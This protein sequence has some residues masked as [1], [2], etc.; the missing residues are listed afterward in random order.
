MLQSWKESAAIC[1]KKYLIAVE[2]KGSTQYWW[3]RYIYWTDKIATYQRFGE[4]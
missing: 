3:N 4:V 1:W 2:V